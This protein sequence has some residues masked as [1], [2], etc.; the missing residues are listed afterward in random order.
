[1][2]FNLKNLLVKWVLP[3]VEKLG[4][5]GLEEVLQDLHDSHPAWYSQTLIQGYPLIDVQLE[6]YV[7]STGK[8]VPMEVVAILKKGL[9]ESAAANNITLPNLDAGLPND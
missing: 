7:K 2:S 1:M 4:E 9:E 6:D 8:K 5:D 3:Q